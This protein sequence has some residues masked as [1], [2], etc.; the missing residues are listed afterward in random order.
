MRYL[1]GLDL[2]GTHIVCGLLDLNGNPVA[3][4]KRLTRAEQG[5]EAV[6]E[7]MASMVQETAAGHGVSLT[8][9]ITVGAGIPGI[10]NPETGVSVQASNLGWSNIP[11]AAALAA[12]L[13][14]PV[15]ID[16]DV[17]MYVYGEAVAGAGR[18]DKHVFGVTIG[19]GIAS[20]MINEGNIYY[21]AQFYA[22]EFGHIPLDGNDLP[23]KCGLRGC[24]ET[25]VSANGI[26]A[27]AKRAVSSG[28]MLAGRQSDVEQITARDVSEAC[29]EGDP[30]AKEIMD[31]T[32]ATLGKALA[33]AVPL[34]SP[35]VIIIGGGGAMAGESLFRPLRE[36]L[37]GRLHNKFRERVRIEP[38][39]HMEEAGVIGSA[40]RAYERQQHAE[41][42]SDMNE[43]GILND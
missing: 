6:L 25:L 43:G 21:G 28:R 16:N 42:K 19:T 23:C 10:V 22:G 39:Q 38:A 29:A 31:F 17:K 36:T 27:Q 12:K 24:L 15:H 33:A 37:F 3:M 1:V 14:L 26:A 2:G 30:L 20:A 13:G 18:N 7:R 34:L 11:V 35:D 9:I 41:R 32:G 4:L 8:D 5:A 40:I